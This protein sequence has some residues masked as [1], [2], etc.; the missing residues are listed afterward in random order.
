MSPADWPLTS[1]SARTDG[2]VG[3][4][5]P[6]WTANSNQDAS[7]DVCGP[8]ART[9][10]VNTLSS[11][12]TAANNEE[13]MYE[14]RKLEV[15]RLLLPLWGKVHMVCRLNS[16]TDLMQGNWRVRWFAIPFHAQL[17]T[18]KQIVR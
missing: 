9:L 13:S 14:K 8:A 16:L 4:T 3:I 12:M 7:V 2:N 18:E 15:F 11:R 10:W 5:N 6:G 17:D 1:S